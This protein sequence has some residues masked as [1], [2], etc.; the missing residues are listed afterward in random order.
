MRRLLLL[1]PV[2]PLLTTALLAQGRERPYFRG[3]LGFSGGQYS[4][5]T[6]TQS[7]DDRTDAGLFQAEFEATSRHGIGG[8][9]RFESMVSDDDLFVRNGAPRNEARAG[10]L[11]GHFTY[12]VEQHRFAMPIRVGVLLHG[13]S[14]EEEVSGLETTYASIG[15]YFEVEPE[16]TLVRRGGFR[17]TAYGQFG[18]GVGATAIDIDNDFRDYESATGFVGFEAGTRL[19][20]GPAEIGVGYIARFQSMDESDVES[21]QVALGYDA[22]YH[23]V[24]LTFGVVF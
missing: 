21:G 12:R 14:L 18:V 22:D 2:L 11:F 5:E 15:P 17:W 4:F 16:L 1:L 20:F 10:S 19:R 6:D 9:I 24:L 13:L 8:G 3:S 7:L 23:G